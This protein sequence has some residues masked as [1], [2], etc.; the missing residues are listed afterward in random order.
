MRFA[1][2]TLCF[3]LL[4]LAVFNSSAN[5][6][7]PPPRVVFDYRSLKSE[8]GEGEVERLPGGFALAIPNTDFSATDPR[9][10]QGYERV[11]YVYGPHRDVKGILLGLNVR[12]HFQ[13]DDETQALRT[14]R[15]IARLLR[16]HREKFGQEAVFPRATE[17]ADVW[18]SPVAGEDET[19]GGL[20]WNSHV[21]VFSV[22]EERTATEWVRTIAHEWGHMTLPA[23]RGFSEPETDAA[24]YLGERLHFK[25]MNA[26]TKTSAVADGTTPTLLKN[27]CD[28][29]V[30]PL[31]ERFQTIGPSS[32]LLN[33][34][35]A[36]AMDFYIGMALAF[37]DAYGSKVAG[38]A[39][40]SIDGETPKRLLA[41]MKEVVGLSDKLVVRLPA[42]T[43]LSKAGYAVT[44]D[45]A[46]SVQIA[47][48]TPL[49]VRPSAPSALAIK[50]PGWKSLRVADGE[51]TTVTL[52]RKGGAAR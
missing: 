49:L 24:G 35:S 17:I 5:A 26:E 48:R 38:R 20:T 41:A 28:K 1:T 23:A 33:E 50:S 4:S 7:V 47:D 11:A 21:F 22:R 46:G 39:L 6:G 42:W 16:L 3:L 19:I 40:F 12:V 52:R 8:I 43:P 9:F 10:G 36:E 15:L 14:S 13:K 25:W 44:S 31:I 45:A 18:L 2:L 51:V 27:Y 34:T 37:D 30:R 29:Q 32:P